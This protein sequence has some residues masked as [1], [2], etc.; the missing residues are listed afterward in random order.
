VTLQAPADRVH[1]V[2][3]NVPVLFVVKVT[4]PVGVIPP[5]PEESAAVAVQVVG[6]LSRTLAGEHETVVVEE[7]IVEAI[8]KLPL[9]PLCTLSPPYVPVIS[10]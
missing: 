7:R 3:L 10:A 6:V 1:V 8:V 9:L 2:E 4:V 5:I